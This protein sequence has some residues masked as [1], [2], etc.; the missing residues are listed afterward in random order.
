MSVSR[1]Q[2]T[3]SNQA[4]TTTDSYNSTNTVN[5]VFDNVGNT[6]VYF[7]SD[8]PKETSAGTDNTKL[9][10]IGGGVILAAI[11]LRRKGN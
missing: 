1:P 2:T 4:M 7:N 6:Q 10:A 3:S 5:R 8:K 11:L 9:I